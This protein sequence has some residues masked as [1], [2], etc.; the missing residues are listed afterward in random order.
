MRLI[1]TACLTL[2]LSGCATIYDGTQQTISLS[3]NAQD[4][5]CEITQNGAVVVPESA[6]PSAHILPR[7]DGNLI[8]TCQAPG[9]ETAK[10][11]LIAG[12]N[13]KTVVLNAPV[14]LSGA[15]L[16][17]AFGGSAEYQDRAYIYLRRRNAA[18]TDD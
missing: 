14:I 2:V 9:Y 16:D 8:V 5:T 3:S 18:P 13:P 10:Q 4:A 12:K 7:I 11:A 15:A 6:V 17:A 1:S